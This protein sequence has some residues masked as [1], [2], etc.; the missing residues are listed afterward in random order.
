MIGKLS[1]V[2]WLKVFILVKSMS[3]ET[4]LGEAG[5]DCRLTALEAALDASTRSS[6][7]ALV[8]FSS[9]FS[10]AATGT[11]TD[12]LW[13]AARAFIIPQVVDSEGKK[14]SVSFLL[15]DKSLRVG[16]SSTLD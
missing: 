7:L 14:L 8:T 11:S 16:E 4:E 12:L 13:L 3:S 10:F 2:K 6:I 9:S 1:Q 15:S 5:L